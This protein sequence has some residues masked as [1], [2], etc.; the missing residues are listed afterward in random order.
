MVRACVARLSAHHR[1]VVLLRDFEGLDTAEVAALLC[2]RPQAVKM[3]L[4]RAHAALR[5]LLLQVLEKPV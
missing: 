2:I 1:T 5:V 3:R 4:C